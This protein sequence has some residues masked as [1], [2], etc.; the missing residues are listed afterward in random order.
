[1]STDPAASHDTP[2]EVPSALPPEEPL[3][4]AELPA[5]GDS[6]KTT[7]VDT[8]I[9]AADPKFSVDSDPVPSVL[10]PELADTDPPEAPASLA[11]SYRVLFGTLTLGP[12]QVAGKGSIVELGDNDARSLLAAGTVEKA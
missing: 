6:S 10:A 9:V 12:Q 1:M 4:V 8:S 7:F 11:G 3:T 2:V 5:T